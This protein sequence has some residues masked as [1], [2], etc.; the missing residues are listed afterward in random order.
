M[1]ESLAARPMVYSIQFLRHVDGHTEPEVMD[2]ECAQAS[3][4]HAAQ[5]LAVSV[6]QETAR[7]MGAGGYRVVENSQGDVFIWWAPAEVA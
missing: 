4:L 6:W 7:A 3:D 5:N 2:I 1:P